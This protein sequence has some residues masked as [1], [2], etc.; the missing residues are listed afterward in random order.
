MSPASR[1]AA[2]RTCRSSLIKACS[3]ACRRRATPGWRSIHDQTRL[4]PPGPALGGCRVKPYASWR[5]GLEDALRLSAAVTATVAP[6]TWPRPRLLGGRYITGPGVGTSPAD[7]EVIGQRTRHVLCRPAGAGG[8][9]DSSAP[10]AAGV[11]ACITALRDRVFD[12]RPA[13]RLTFAIQGLGHV[14]RLIAENLAQQGASLVVATPTRAARGRPAAGVHASSGQGNC[15]P[16]KP[17][18][19]CPPHSAASS[20]RR[21]CPPSAATRSPDPRTT[22][23]RRLRRGPAARARHHLGTRPGRKRR[24]HRRLRRPRDRPPGRTRGSGPVHRHRR[25]ARRHTRR[26]RP[27]RPAAPAAARQ[28]IRQR[29]PELPEQGAQPAKATASHHAARPVYAAARSD[30]R[31]VLGRSWP[32]AGRSRPV[33]SWDTWAAQAD[34][35]SP[36]LYPWASTGKGLTRIE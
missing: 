27:Q 12:G 28:R 30:L 25:A 20:P 8:S 19:S 5:D 22:S 7:M 1:M 29:L 10:T 4:H 14:G 21:P 16:A 11:L 6:P 17:T 33:H 32:L 13:S 9:G 34:A 23:R 35:S 15:S 36:W 31:Q 18:S 2:S 3:A 24:G 26:I